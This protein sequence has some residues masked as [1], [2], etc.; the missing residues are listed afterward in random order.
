MDVFDDSNKLLSDV[1][2]LSNSDLDRINN[3]ASI[4]ISYGAKGV[5]T[6]GKSFYREDV[7][8][9]KIYLAHKDDENVLIAIYKAEYYNFY[10]QS[11]RYIIYV[12]LVYKNVTKDTISTLEDEKVEAPE[13]YFDDGHTTYFY[14]YSSLEEAIKEK[15]DPLRKDYK[16]TE[17]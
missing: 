11:D 9:Q 8:R 13:F 7:E 2:E 12:P 17:K 3:D 6:S 4:K 5:S 14:G 1:S 10:N 15:I 16:I